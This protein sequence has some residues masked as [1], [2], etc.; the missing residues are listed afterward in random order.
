V[1]GRLGDSELIPADPDTES[2]TMT[3]FLS[4]SGAATAALLLIGAGLVV[5]CVL[6]LAVISLVK[7]TL[8]RQAR[9]DR[10]NSIIGA[11]R[12]PDLEE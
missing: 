2:Q 9:T 8:N 7:W 12:A 4:T 5:L 3:T 6:G 1:T 11:L 10:A